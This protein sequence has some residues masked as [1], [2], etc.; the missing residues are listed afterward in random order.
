MR[1]R[2]RGD[3]SFLFWRDPHLDRCGLFARF[4]FFGVQQAA[5]TETKAITPEKRKG[6]TWDP[7]PNRQE[8]IG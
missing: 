3:R 4:S 5:T 8:L 1:V 7:T 2:F 6:F